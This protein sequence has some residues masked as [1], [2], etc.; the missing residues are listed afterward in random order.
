MKPYII[1]CRL[2]GRPSSE[3]FYSRLAPVAP[4]YLNA[5]LFKTSNLPLYLSLSLSMSLSLPLSVSV[6]LVYLILKSS[7]PL[8]FKR[9]FSTQSFGSY[10]SL[11]VGSEQ[12]LIHGLPTWGGHGARGQI[13]FEPVR[14]A[15]M[16]PSKLPTWGPLENAG[17][18]W[19]RALFRDAL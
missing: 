4:V 12:R 9:P 2:E 8:L 11:E 13:H 7:P 17:L 1:C 18:F 14:A 19:M 15:H 5:R 6:A 10:S 3:G 16:A